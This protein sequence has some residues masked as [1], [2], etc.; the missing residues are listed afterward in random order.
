MGFCWSWDQS[1]GVVLKR[2]CL[3]L[4]FIPFGRLTGPSIGIRAS[5]G[6]PYPNRSKIYE[7]DMEQGVGKPPFFDG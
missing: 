4:P 7:G 3:V 6:F 2:E 5:K 1:Q